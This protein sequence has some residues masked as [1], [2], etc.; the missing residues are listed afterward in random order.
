VYEC[1]NQWWNPLKRCTS[2]NLVDMG[3]AAVHAAVL[4]VA[5]ATPTAVY[6]GTARRLR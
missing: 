2:S 6:K 5:A 3:W 1:R 4:V